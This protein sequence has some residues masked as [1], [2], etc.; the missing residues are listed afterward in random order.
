M[1]DFPNHRR[2]L[3]EGWRFI[4]HSFAQVNQFQLLELMQR[5]LDA[6]AHRDV[7][8][9]S[10]KWKPVPGLL[11]AQ[12]GEKLRGIRSPLPGE[13]FDAVYRIAAPYDFSDS[14]QADRTFV[15]CPSEF[16]II[17]QHIVAGNEPFAQAVA[18][19]SCTIVTPSKWSAQGLIESGADPKRVVIVPHGVAMELFRPPT[20]SQRDFFRQR[21]GN[22]RFVFLNIGTMVGNKGIPMLLKAFAAVL[23]KHPDV[24]LLLKGTDALY[25][26]QELLSEKFELLTTAETQ[27]VVPRIK[28]IGASLEA[29]DV[30]ALY[31][32]ADAYVAPYFAE[33]FNLPVLEAI[34]CG[35]PA[36]CT[37]GGPTD[38]FVRDDLALRINSRPIRMDSGL[39][40]GGIALEPNL[41]HLIELMNRAVEDQD[42]A[43]HVRSAGPAYV[44]ANFTWR[45]AVQRLM[46]VLF[47]A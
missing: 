42:L 46:K 20:E 40:A 21:L 10:S 44:A 19:S 36:I 41:E 13:R 29:L 9:L 25:R 8:Y 32:A 17:H 43:R 45:H 22:P 18:K 24:W 38:D 47:P 34:A 37:A 6:M 31:Q 39:R 5:G 7:P 27:R 35:I 26:S 11:P 33:A 23:E 14:P 3:V 28:Y 1:P 30:A 16:R 15:F 4:A 2:L 12:M